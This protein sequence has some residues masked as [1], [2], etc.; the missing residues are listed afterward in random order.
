MRPRPQRGACRRSVSSTVGLFCGPPFV[1]GPRASADLAADRVGACGDRSER[2]GNVDALQEERD[3]LLAAQRQL[4][5][6]LQQLRQDNVCAGVERISRPALRTALK[7]GMD[8]AILAGR[9]VARA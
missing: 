8:G 2:F 4:E 1:A 5:L 9:A 3:A 6:K 7:N